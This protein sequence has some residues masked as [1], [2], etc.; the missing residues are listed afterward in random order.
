MT[1]LPFQWARRMRVKQVL[2][3]LKLQSFLEADAMAHIRFELPEA[4]HVIHC[5]LEKDE[6][7]LYG[8]SRL[9]FNVGR[10]PRGVY[11]GI[12]KRNTALRDFRWLHMSNAQQDKFDLGARIPIH[13]VNAKRLGTLL[14]GMV[15]ELEQC[16]Q[17]LIHLYEIHGLNSN[18]F[19]DR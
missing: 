14:V 19:R 8:I 11:V 13:L 3:Q 7:A 18:V 5:V 9:R 12:S 10:T 4:T 2:T 17:V 6:L 15:Q 16:R 1:L